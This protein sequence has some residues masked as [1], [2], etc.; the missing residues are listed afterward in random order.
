[1][2]VKKFK[3]IL[4]FIIILLFNLLCSPINVD[5]IWNYGFSVNMYRGLIPYLDFNM[6]L[7]PFYPFF[8]S[9]FFYIFGNS[10]LV[11]HVV[12]AVVLTFC[13]FLL[14]KMYQEK[15]Y[16]FFLF[17]FF[18]V[19][20]A[21]PNYNLFLF[22]LLVIVIYVEE[23][24]VSKYSWAYYLIGVMLGLCI[25]TKQTVGFCL[26][27]PSLYY[28]KQKKVLLQRF[29]G[30]LVPVGIFI[31]YLF[32]TGSFYS[33]I[34]LCI[35][36]LFEFSGNHKLEPILGTLVVLMIVVTIYFIKKDSKELLNYYALAF[37]S[38]IIP[39]VDVYHF[40]I[41][42]LSF[43]LV[44]CKKMKKQYIHYP[45]FSIISV[46]VLAVLNAYN[47][48]FSFSNYPNDITH[49]EYRYISPNSYRFTK[50]VL[51]YM[52]KN[53]DRKMIFINSDAYY[54]K[55]IM[56]MDISYL[57]L[58]NLGNLGYRGSDY[59][60]EV[61]KNSK[62]AIFLVNP[63]EYGGYRQTD[64]RVIKYIMTHG[65]KI[66]NLGLYDIYIFDKEKE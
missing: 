22:V 42:F 27:L 13:F 50:Q 29:L 54:F 46:L 37:Y 44:I 59:L 15:S 60:L 64:Q 1:M 2:Y 36:G 17:F 30:F 25:L 53:K 21:F 10:I 61:I 14:D 9:L 47:N 19:N 18:P 34:N 56:D 31:I 57:D 4:I 49:F 65:K 45:S 5:E 35:L 33:F 28:I 26:L 39:I 62:D 16:L 51:D 63:D 66:K 3:Y 8:M 32:F 11:F 52:K 41:A 48:H 7:T 12:N 23:N 6:V 40:F 20:Y 24:F 38:L 43:L 58:I 55:L